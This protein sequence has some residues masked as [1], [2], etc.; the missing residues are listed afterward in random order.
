M[1]CVISFHKRCFK[2]YKYFSY[3]FF[4]LSILVICIKPNLCMSKGTQSIVRLVTMITHGLRKLEWRTSEGGLIDVSGCGIV[5][6]ELFLCPQ[7]IVAII[8]SMVVATFIVRAIQKIWVIGLVS[9]RRTHVMYC[10]LFML[11]CKSNILLHEQK[12][13][14]SQ[15]TGGTVATIVYQRIQSHEDIVCHMLNHYL[16]KA[17]NTVLIYTCL[18]ATKNC[19]L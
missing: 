17:L 18:R 12:D 16:K 8:G 1:F 11:P 3:N 5:E 14:T 13:V 4:Y 7:T 2:Q 9:G 10:H 6:G 19:E 15:V